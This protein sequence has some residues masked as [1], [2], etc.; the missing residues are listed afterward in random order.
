MNLPFSEW[1]AVFPDPRLVSAIVGRVTFNAS[2]RPAPPPIG[3]A[4]ARPALGA[5]EPVCTRRARLM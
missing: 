1:G 4:P 5:S 3:S 2:S